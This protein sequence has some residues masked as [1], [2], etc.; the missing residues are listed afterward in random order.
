L[1]AAD[2]FSRFGAP[3]PNFL[4][5]SA[6]TF[7]SR[8]ATRSSVGSRVPKL[9][10]CR[11]YFSSR[12]SAYLSGVCRLGLV[13]RKTGLLGS[14]KSADTWYGSFPLPLASATSQV[15]SADTPGLASRSDPASSWAFC[16]VA[17][18]GASPRTMS[19]V[20]GT[21]S[22]IGGSRVGLRQ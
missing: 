14:T 8:L 21:F 2:F 9:S 10:G 6:A 4:R 19:S 12:A 3:G 20:I 1:S 17:S 13:D 16:Q 5:S 22:G 18:S 11:A 15:P 7:F